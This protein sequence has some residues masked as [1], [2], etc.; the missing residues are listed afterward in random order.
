MKVF[1]GGTCNDSS[2]RDTLIPMFEDNGISFFNPVVS[3]WTPDCIVKEEQE[4]KNADYTLFVITPRIQGVYSIAEVTQ[5]S[6][7]DPEGTI[8]VILKEEDK[9]YTFT[10]GQIKSL[11]AVSALVSR[12]FATCLWDLHYISEYIVELTY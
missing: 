11:E 12:N 1:L 7:E 3:D 6:N 9:G 8:L 4:K 10:D 5:Q 2:W